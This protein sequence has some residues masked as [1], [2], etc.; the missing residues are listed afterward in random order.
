[1]ASWLDTVPPDLA[2]LRDTASGLVFHYL[3]NGDITQYGFAKERRAEINLRY[4]DAMFA[5][6]HDLDPAPPD[7]ERTPTDRIV[8]CCRDITLLFVALARHH[9]IPARARV[10]FATY[11]L[12]G[13]ALD[14]VITEVWDGDRWRLVEPQFG[15]D[16][17]DP[18]DGTALDLLDVPRDR[19]LVGADA[20]R[21]CRSGARE[22]GRFVVWP[23]NPL[24]FLRGLPYVSHNLV[25][26]LAALNKDEMI[27]WDLWGPLGKARTVPD[28]VAARMDA[29]AATVADAELDRILAAYTGELRVPGTVVSVTPPEHRPEAVI[30]RAA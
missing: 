21:D 14:H 6:L 24:P 3:A 5:R 15:S 18:A 19:F 16:H 4:A 11:L 30:L 27:L 10:G 12:P 29:L 17:V 28:D 26:D 9:G 23:E 22:A 1:M 20:W 25:F 8:G 2:S 7:H 13:W